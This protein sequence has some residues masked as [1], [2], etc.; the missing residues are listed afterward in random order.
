MRLL[1]YNIFGVPWSRIRIADTANWIFSSKADI[2]CLQ[3]V[4]SIHHRRYL[5]KAAEE[6]GY[7]AYYPADTLLIPFFECGSGLLTLIKPHFVLHSPPRF[8]EFRIR[9]GFDRFVKKG[10]FMLDLCYGYHNF[11]VY[12][13][14]MQSDISELFCWRINYR[15]AREVQEEQLFVSAHG[16]DLPL[17][18]GDMNMFSFKCFQKVD[19]NFHATFPRTGEHLDNLLCLSR[20]SHKID[21]YETTYFDEVD[22]SDHIPIMYTV[23]LLCRTGRSKLA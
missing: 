17:L 23:D 6:A 20:D 1:T 21:Y 15:K 7:V 2:I 10:Y 14:H 18:L 19:G 11:Q 16:K 12:N 9:H 22:L 4:F 5:V 3:E 13:T 8:E